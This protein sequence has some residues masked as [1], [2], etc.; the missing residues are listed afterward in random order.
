MGCG[1][2]EV[3]AHLQWASYSVP[4]ASL[5]CEL[6]NPEPSMSCKLAG[7]TVVYRQ[8]CTERIGQMRGQTGAHTT[9]GGGEP[10]QDHVRA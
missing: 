8:L 4:P 6:G 3:D 9:E 7:K 5:G 10:W 2:N 1:M